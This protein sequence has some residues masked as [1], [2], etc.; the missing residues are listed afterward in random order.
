[1]KI[2]SRLLLPLEWLKI[3]GR[4]ALGRQLFEVQ[5]QQYERILD[6]THHPV[7]RPAW[8]VMSGMGGAVTQEKMSAYR[9]H[10]AEISAS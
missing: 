6:A 2:P 4:T 10:S 3:E 9:H 7:I 1:M 5:L 8:R